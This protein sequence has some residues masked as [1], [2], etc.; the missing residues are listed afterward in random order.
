V[1]SVTGKCRICKCLCSCTEEKYG[2]SSMVN[3]VASTRKF[4]LS[5]QLDGHSDS[6]F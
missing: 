2:E 6:P 4:I 3:I 1:I 5:F